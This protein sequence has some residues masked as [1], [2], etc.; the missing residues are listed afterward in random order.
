[1]KNVVAMVA[2]CVGVSCVGWCFGTGVMHTEAA[3]VLLTC[4][5]ALT[6]SCLPE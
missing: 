4:W 6:W 1:M 2:L 3:A 5:V